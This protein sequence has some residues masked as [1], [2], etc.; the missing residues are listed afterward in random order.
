MTTTDRARMTQGM[1]SFYDRVSSTYDQTEHTLFQ[2]FGRDAIGELGLRAGDRVLD[3]ATGRGALLFPAA[4][5]VGEAGDVVGVDVSER[6]IAHLSRE[7]AERGITH[8]SAR[9]MGADQLAYP[10]NHFD[11]LTCGFALF[12]FPEASA[13]LAE[14]RR[15]LRPGGQLLL[16]T[17][18]RDPDS[19]FGAGGWYWDL[20]GSMLPPP[21][22]SPSAVD[23]GTEASLRE[24]L[25]A[26]GFQDIRF[27]VKERVYHYRDEDAWWAEQHTHGGKRV[28]ELMPEETLPLFKQ[29]VFDRLQAFRKGPGLSCRVPVLLTLARK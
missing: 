18:R 1:A 22:A 15:V 23:F 11:C 2:D 28:F 6:M 19:A 5:A 9:V 20:V 7:I 17:W 21:P 13:A 10:E 25:T 3:L 16:S 27:V 29:K 8:A 26:A 14:A 24:L 4:E 12:F